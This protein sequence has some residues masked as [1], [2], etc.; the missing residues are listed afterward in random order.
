MCFN[1]FLHICVCIFPLPEK[2][3]YGQIERIL[4]RDAI[5]SEQDRETELVKKLGE[6]L[7]LRN[8]HER[9]ER[10]ALRVEKLKQRQQEHREVWS[11]TVIS[12]DISQHSQHLTCMT[13]SSM[14]YC[15]YITLLKLGK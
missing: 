11:Y 2:S 10:V 13:Q 14:K 15:N 5:F 12:M 9:H 6:Q 8:D 7:Q 3:L 4:C 1:N